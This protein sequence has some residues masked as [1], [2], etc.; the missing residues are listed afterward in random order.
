MCLLRRRPVFAAVCVA[1]FISLIGCSG[2]VSSTSG[3]LPTAAAATAITW[4]WSNATQVQLA[5]PNGSLE[6]QPWTGCYPALPP[7]ASCGPSVPV[8]T[9]GTA[10]LRLGDQL[11]IAPAGVTYS[12]TMTAQCATLALL[13]TTTYAITQGNNGSCVLAATDSSGD[14]AVIPIS[15]GQP[16][17]FFL[18]A[19][20]DGKSANLASP[21]S[22]ATL[23]R[24]ASLNVSG[25]VS[26]IG[27]T[28]STAGVTAAIIGTCASI[29][30]SV[31]PGTFTVLG[32]AVGQCAII[33]SD[34][35]TQSV[36]V[37][38]AVS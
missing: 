30:E 17:R 12:V 33:V 6:F 3:T 28:P 4:T 26:A 23:A 31:N 8:A 38:L 29:S 25:S 2:G 36:A 7:G 19:T 22:S 13:T 16:P 37:L 14:L 21:W 20:V 32:L 35:A 10:T 9:L 24:G 34:G 27:P 1:L 15:A 11:G 18:Q 5:S